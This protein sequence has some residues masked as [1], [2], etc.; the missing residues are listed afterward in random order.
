[1]AKARPSGPHKQSPEEKKARMRAY[2][3]KNKSKWKTYTRERAKRMSE[4]EK[5]ALRVRQREYSRAWYEQHRDEVL[6][7]TSRYQKDNAKKMA[8]YKANWYQQN[9]ARVAA[10]RHQHYHAVVKVRDQAAKQNRTFLSLKEAAALLG[11][12]YEKFRDWVYEGH[13]EATRTNGGQYRLHRD[14][15]KRLQTEGHHLPLEVRKRIGLR[16]KRDKK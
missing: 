16:N 13:C 14:V 12:N 11:A 5:M 9:K 8:D 10:R 1:M 2:Y 6:A 15:V 4:A 3:R 7:R